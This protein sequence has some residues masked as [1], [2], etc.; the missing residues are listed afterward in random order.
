MC[1]ILALTVSPEA[2][3]CVPGPA[4]N[5]D[6]KAV[7]L[8]CSRPLFGDPHAFRVKPVGA[9]S[10]LEFELLD[11]VRKELRAMK[12]AADDCE[13]EKNDLVKRNLERLE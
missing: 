9:P 6:K 7:A 3:L 13:R 5:N 1:L 2:D 8:H 4:I 10:A 11:A 12:I